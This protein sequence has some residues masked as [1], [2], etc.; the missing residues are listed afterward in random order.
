MGYQYVQ[1][2]WQV[3]DGDASGQGVSQY[4]Q[5]KVRI[6]DLIIVTSA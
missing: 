4:T 5:Q 2:T 3:V 6:V 1:N